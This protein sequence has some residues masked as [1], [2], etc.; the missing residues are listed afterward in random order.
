MYVYVCVCVLVCV[1][2]SV[3]LSFHCPSPAPYCTH[4]GCIAPPLSFYVLCLVLAPGLQS[5]DQFAARSR[6]QLC[7]VLLHLH[8]AAALGHRLEAAAAVVAQVS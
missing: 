3:C 1:C 8:G 7:A 5:C 4:V 2:V 6:L